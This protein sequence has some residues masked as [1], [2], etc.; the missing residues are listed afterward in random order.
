MKQFATHAPLALRAVSCAALALMTVSCGLRESTAQPSTSAAEPPPP[1]ATAFHL[2]VAPSGADT[3]AGTEKAPFRTIER[4]AQAALPDTTV[5]VAPGSYVGGFKTLAN[6]TPKARVYYLSTLRWGAKIVPPKNSDNPSAWDNRGNYVD[7]VGFDVDGTVYQGGVKWLNGIYSGGSYDSIR[8]NHVHHIATTVACTSDDGS[9][10]NVES[11]YHGIKSEVIGNNIHDIGPAGCRSI[12]GINVNTPATVANNIVY[13]VAYAGIHLWHDAT[14]VVVTN[15]TLAASECGILVGG[16][17]FYYTAGPNDHTEVSNNI[18]Y[19]NKNGIEEQ[20]AT[21][22][23]NSYSNNLVFQNPRGDWR[24]ANGLAH[25]AS[26]AAAPQF[27]DYSRTGTPD[28]RLSST[29]P[30]IGKG[31]AVHAQPSDFKSAP[32]NAATGVDIGA[33]QH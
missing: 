20:G 4:A 24:L 28:F 16:G 13:R 21:G 19:D 2:Y 30:A 5:H 29:S 3:N 26:V 1:P 8:N 9:G 11:Y 15:N 25:R 10:I 18:V 32:R 6:G 12:Q 7:I 33:Y 31:S 27:L 23:N 17:D 14:N 22:K